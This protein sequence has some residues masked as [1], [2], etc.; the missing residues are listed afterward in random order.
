MLPHNSALDEGQKTHVLTVGN[1]WVNGP[2]D[3][4]L[5]C[6]EDTDRVSEGT[7]LWQRDGNIE[8]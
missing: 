1:L 4:S 2:E 6:S 3:A 7:S 8:I 5:V